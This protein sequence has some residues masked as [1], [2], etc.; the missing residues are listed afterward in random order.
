M[1]WLYSLT[2]ASERPKNSPNLNIIAG[3]QCINK[4]RVHTATGS[5]LTNGLTS[6]LSPSA[7]CKPAAMGTVDH[8]SP[9]LVH[10]TIASSNAVLWLHKTKAR[11][12]SYTLIGCVMA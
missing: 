5:I 10:D 6:W 1:S 8:S 11:Q 3:Y 9:L 7:S 12:R 4:I 2:S